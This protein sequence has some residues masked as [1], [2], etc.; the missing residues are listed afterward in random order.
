MAENIRLQFESLVCRQQCSGSEKAELE[1]AKRR[2]S[3]RPVRFAPAYHTEINS[4]V[5]QTMQDF[6]RLEVLKGDCHARVR[7]GK[8]RQARKQQPLDQTL[9]RADDQSTGCPA[10]VPRNSSSARSV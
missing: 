5:K 2:G 3:Q 4:S 8:T 9:T 10:H 1:F 7:R 6:V